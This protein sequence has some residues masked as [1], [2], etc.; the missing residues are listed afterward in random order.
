MTGS[1]TLAARRG[2][3][4]SCPS[5]AW[6]VWPRCSC[7]RSGSKASDSC[8]GRGLRALH[9]ARTGCASARISVAGA[10]VKQSCSSFTHALIS[11]YK[12]PVQDAPAIRPLTPL[13]VLGVMIGQRHRR[14][15]NRQHHTNQGEA[16]QHQGGRKHA[17]TRP[18]PAHPTPHTKRKSGIAPRRQ[19]CPRPWCCGRPTAVPSS[20]YRPAAH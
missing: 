12:Q 15:G 2:P 6:I 11:S 20:P 10:M 18:T 9:S 17:E 19:H 4:M 16:V 14:C 13:P 8:D 1:Q 3:G 7:P 5:K